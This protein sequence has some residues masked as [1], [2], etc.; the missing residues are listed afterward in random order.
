LNQEKFRNKYGK[1]N[2]NLELMQ[3]LS[4]YGVELYVCAQATAAKDIERADMN[5]YVKSSLSA[6]SVLSNYQLNGYVF[7]P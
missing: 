1:D 4:D 6:L 5:P 2:P 3:L 7:M